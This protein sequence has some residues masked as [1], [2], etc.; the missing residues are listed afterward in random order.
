[1]QMDAGCEWMP[2]ALNVYRKAN[3]QGVWSAVGTKHLEKVFFVE[4]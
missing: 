1:M 2:E 4:V 3:S